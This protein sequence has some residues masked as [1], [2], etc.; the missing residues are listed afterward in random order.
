MRKA[1]AD[2]IQ[3]WLELFRSELSVAVRYPGRPLK[4]KKRNQ[5]VRGEALPR[6]KVCCHLCGGLS[7]FR[8]SLRWMK[9]QRL[10]KVQERS[11]AKDDSNQDVGLR[12]G[13]ADSI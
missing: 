13:I 3:T 2:Q 11:K 6:K 10:W 1:I 5:T 4:G 12:T 8:Y 7:H 9:G